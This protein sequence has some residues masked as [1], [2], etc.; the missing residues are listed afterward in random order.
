MPH[1]QMHKW[2]VLA[3]DY[4]YA[5]AGTRLTA[6]TVSQGKA[7][8]PLPTEAVPT[9]MLMEQQQPLQ[10]LA[11]PAAKVSGSLQEDLS[12]I[13]HVSINLHMTRYSTIHGR[14]L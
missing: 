5:D 13:C 12:Y 11:T 4:Q 1:V 10:T 7:Y 2:S 3:A 9:T 8:A 14:H 6:G